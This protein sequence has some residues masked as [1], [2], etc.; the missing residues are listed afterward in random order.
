MQRNFTIV[1][2][3]DTH[4]E[5][6]LQED[7]VNQPFGAGSEVTLTIEGV[8]ELSTENDPPEIEFSLTASHI[9]I[10][11]LSAEL[12]ESI[13]PGVHAYQCFV[14]LEAGNRQCVASGNITIRKRLVDET[15]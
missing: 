14:L 11:T 8:A 1:Q 13:P 10:A 4:F 15:A 7:G 9:A 2:G 6:P 12:T 3:T 5:I